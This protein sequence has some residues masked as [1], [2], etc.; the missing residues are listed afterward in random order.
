[1]P[2]TNR[3]V[4]YYSDH[5]PWPRPQP[6]I[7]DATSARQRSADPRAWAFSDAD[8]DVLHEVIASRRDIRRYR[9]EPVPAD[10]WRRVLS[11]AHAAPSVGHSQPWRFILVTDAA[12]REQAALL[13][14]RERLTQAANLTEDAGRRL[15]DLQLEGIRE[16]PLG[17]VVCCDRRTPAAGV[18]GRAT[19]PDAD[20]W[21]CACAIENLWIAARAEGL[22]VGWVTLFQPQDLAALLHLPDGVETLGWLC[23]GWPDERPPAPGLERAGWSRRAPLDEV[24]FTE[25]WP[26][27]TGKQAPAPPRSHLRAPDSGA[28]VGVR[29]NADRLLT[30][31]GSLGVLDRAVDR[32]LSLGLRELDTGTLVLVAADHPVAGLGVSAYDR[33]VTADVLAAAVAGQAVGTAAARAVGLSTVVIDARAGHAVVPGAVSIPPRHPLGDLLTT[34]A[35]GGDDAEHLLATGRT[36]GRELGVA[37]VVILGEVGI[38]NTTVAA[39][40]AAAL[41]NLTAADTAG[42]GAGADSAMLTRKIDVVSGALSRIYVQCPPPLRDPLAALRAVGGA[43]IAVLAGITLGAAEAGALVLLDGLAT[44]VAALI[45]VRL[46][47]AV[48]AHLVAGQRSREA[49]HNSVLTALGQEPLLDLRIRAGEGA[50]ACLAFGLLQTAFRTRAGTATTD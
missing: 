17:V 29:D 34:D 6:L 2:V 1:M 24:M 38:G 18:L 9:P 33:S 23:V 15:L 21:S 35:L 31:P 12:T 20:L 13:A 50:G 36:L 30:P 19:F 22:G 7:G 3:R 8:R 4:P 27:E 10:I 14:D 41:L 40:L 16:A 44:S 46:E 28:V 45:A 43:E 39:A 25:R 11:A 48:A 49:A 42:L 26:A 47:Q 5:V 37:G 32:A